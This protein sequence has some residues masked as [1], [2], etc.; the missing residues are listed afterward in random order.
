MAALF[1]WLFFTV[2]ILALGSSLS[3]AAQRNITAAPGQNATLPCQLP[4]NKHT[5]YVKWSRPDLEPQYVLLYRDEQL[6][7]ERQHPSFR[8][9]VELQDRQMKDGDV[10]LVLKNV[11]INDTGTYECRVDH[12]RKRIKRGSPLQ[13]EPICIIHLHVAPPTNTATTAAITTGR[14]H[15]GL[16]LALLVFALMIVLIVALT[17]GSVWKEKMKNSCSSSSSS[18]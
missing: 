13:T 18:C 5:V 8:K 9:R 16:I 7:P 2:F 15:F 3:D 1:A 6:D 12:G 17:N 10:S 14:G 4:N 11:T